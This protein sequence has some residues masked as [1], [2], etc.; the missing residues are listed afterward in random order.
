VQLG[1]VAGQPGEADKIRIGD[2]P[3]GASKLHSNKEI[4]KGIAKPGAF[5][6]IHQI[7]LGDT[8]QTRRVH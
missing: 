6:L 1:I 4:G 7:L 3:S 5:F 2:G 8:P